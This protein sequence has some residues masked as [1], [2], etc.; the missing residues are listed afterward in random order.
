MHVYEKYEF[1][2]GLRIC[3]STDGVLSTTASTTGN[4]VHIRIYLMNI[5]I[6]AKPFEYTALLCSIENSHSTSR[7]LD[8]NFTKRPS[9]IQTSSAAAAL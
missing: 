6:K 3:S 4:G 5:I 7:L 8:L 1:Q 9:I 2:S